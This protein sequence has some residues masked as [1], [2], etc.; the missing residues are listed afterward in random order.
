MKLQG[1]PFRFGERSVCFPI[2]SLPRDYSFPHHSS[3]NDP[4]SFPSSVCSLVLDRSTPKKMGSWLGL[5]CFF[6]G[7]LSFL[8]TALFI[9]G[10]IMVEFFKPTLLDSLKSK[11]VSQSFRD[12]LTPIVKDSV[13]TGIVL[14]AVFMVA[15]FL[16]ICLCV[17]GCSRFRA[18]K[19]A[20]GEAYHVF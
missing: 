10:F 8:I 17:L 19:E 15:F 4:P 9:A 14:G 2:F 18:T 12:F 1:G 6:Y 11:H 20:E 7:F 5:C 3:P 16:G 13:T